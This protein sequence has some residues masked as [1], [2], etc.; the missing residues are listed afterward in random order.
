TGPT[1]VEYFEPGTFRLEPDLL[2][3]VLVGLIYSGDI[4]LAVT[5]DKIDS[6]KL[7]L[8]VERS[9]EDLKAFRHVE[10]PKE[11]NVALL[12]TL[13][14]TLGLNPGLAQLATQGQPEPVTQLQDAAAGLV[15]RVL[16]ATTDMPG[17]LSF[18][19]KP[20]L[21]DEELASWRSRLDALKAFTE[22]L[23]PYNTVGKL[24]NLRITAEELESQK[25]NLAVLTSAE[26]LMELVAELGSAASY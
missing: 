2:V 24:K 25:Q 17:R 15:R 21:R 23:Q 20:L 22:S 1:D 3:T 16:H 7:G 13:F 8:L 11:I 18:W 19:G 9:L 12:R 5:G 10:A 6:G 4:V 26:R 14:E